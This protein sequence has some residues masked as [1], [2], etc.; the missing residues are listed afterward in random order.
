ML[1]FEEARLLGRDMRGKRQSAI[2]LFAQSHTGK[3]TAAESFA[4]VANEGAD[5]G[6]CPVVLFSLGSGGGPVYIHRMILKTLGE[7]FPA[8]KD[9]EIIRERSCEAMRDAGTELLIIDEAHEGGRTSSFGPSIT[10]ELKTL[11]NGGYVGIVLLGTEKAE[12]MINKDQE[13]AMRT[14]APCRLGAL[15]WSDEEDQAL[16]TGFLSALDN[17]M[18]RIGIV[19]EPTGLD[20]TELA[21]ALWQA[22]GGVIGQLM[23]VVKQALRA[24]IYAGRNFIAVD[25]LEAAVDDWS[26]ALKLCDA[27]PIKRLLKKSA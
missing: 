10:A 18:V 16:W 24:S 5:E 9:L 25:D 11:L 7:G 20:D 26:M 4:D 13:F 12:S 15:Q 6:K 8:T 14:M 17:E 19:A 1:T 21:L 27:N 23:S 2:C 22:C 3:T